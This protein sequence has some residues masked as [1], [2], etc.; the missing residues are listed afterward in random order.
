MCE[1]HAFCVKFTLFG[2]G[3]A[4]KP[5]P[6]GLGMVLDDDYGLIMKRRDMMRESHSQDRCAPYIF[7]FSI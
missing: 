4:R 5:P 2:L 3:V 7:S 1:A 6:G